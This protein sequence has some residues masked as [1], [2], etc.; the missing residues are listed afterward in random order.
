MACSLPVTHLGGAGRD[1]L[2]TL[3]QYSPQL[4]LAVILHLLQPQLTV[5]NETHEHRRI[6]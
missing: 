2:A 6:P 3:V 4:V 1:A 5:V